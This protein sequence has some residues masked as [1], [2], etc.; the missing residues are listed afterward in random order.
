MNQH[1][2]TVEKT[3]RY[4]SLSEPKSEVKTIWIIL[5][6]YAQ[7]PGYFI[8]KFEPLDSE[9]TLV[10]A[11]EGMH[12]FYQEGF[13]GRVVASWMTKDDREADIEDNI[14]YLN[15]LITKLSEKHPDAKIKVLAF[16]QGGA[17]ACRWAVK[18]DVQ[19]E[20]LVLWAASFP[21]DLDLGVH[22]DKLNELNLLLVMGTRDPFIEEKDIRQVQQLLDEGGIRYD[23]KR[24]DGKHEIDRDALTTISLG[25]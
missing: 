11:A 9:D 17:T 23:L 12:R 21:P 2:L 1:H 5:H 8:R 4:F 22:G 7:H 19:I 16:S 3:A 10:V 15:R 6:G 25:R 18:S 24:F 13:S 14:N 20:Q